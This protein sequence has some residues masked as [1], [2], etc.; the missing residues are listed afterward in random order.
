MKKQSFP[1]RLSVA[2]LERKPKPRLRPRALL[3]GV[4]LRLSPLF[5]LAR[6]G[7]RRRAALEL[8][9]APDFAEEERPARSGSLLLAQSRLHLDVGG[10]G[11][12]FALRH[13]E[14]HLIAFAHAKAIQVV[15]Q[16]EDVRPK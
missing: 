8:I 3:R 11:A 9:E 15:L 6:C 7:G 4:A 12:L 1:N 2:G 5:S 13:A 14:A 16:Q 10:P